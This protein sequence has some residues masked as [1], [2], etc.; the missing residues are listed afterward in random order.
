MI[1]NFMPKKQPT[2][3]EPNAPKPAT[4]NDSVPPDTGSLVQQGSALRSKK[5]K[6]QKEKRDAWKQLPPKQREEETQKS[7]EA[8]STKPKPG[9]EVSHSTKKLEKAKV[10][11]S[12]KE[13]SPDTLKHMTEFMIK[14]FET[15]KKQIECG[16]FSHFNPPLGYHQCF[17]TA[18]DL[19]E[20]PDHLET[21]LKT[22]DIGSV[23]Q[24]AQTIFSRV[25]GLS[26]I[27]SLNDDHEISHLL[28]SPEGFIL[29]VMALAWLDTHSTEKTLGGLV[30]HSRSEKVSG[31]SLP[32]FC[33][34]LKHFMSVV[35]STK[36]PDNCPTKTVT[37]DVDGQRMPLLATAC[38]PTIEHIVTKASP[39]VLE[40]SVFEQLGDS[41][42]FS[43]FFAHII[44]VK[45]LEKSR[46]LSPSDISVKPMVCIQTVV[47]LKEGLNPNVHNSQEMHKL[48]LESAHTEHPPF[49]GQ[50]DPGFPDFRF[51]KSIIDGEGATAKYKTGLHENH[52]EVGSTASVAE[53]ARALK[54]FRGLTVDSGKLAAFLKEKVPFGGTLESFPRLDSRIHLDQQVPI[55]TVTELA[56]TTSHTPVLVAMSDVPLT[57]LIET[58]QALTPGEP[59]PT[60][61]LHVQL[62]QHLGHYVALHAA[63]IGGSIQVFV[64][65]S[66]D[67]PLSA[68]IISS[69]LP[70]ISIT[71]VPLADQIHDQLGANTCGPIALAVAQHLVQGGSVS[72]LVAGNVPQAVIENAQA[73]VA[74]ISAGVVV[75][76]VP[77]TSLGVEQLPS[78]LE[79]I[80]THVLTPCTTEGEKDPSATSLTNEGG[81]IQQ[82]AFLATG[83]FLA[84]ML[85]PLEGKLSNI[86]L[87]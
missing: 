33:A 69:L 38:G 9:A 36:M 28:N 31:R 81:M 43:G 84:G 86:D 55:E 6:E 13:V 60:A 54:P 85:F 19:C 50:S 15:I 22:K 53:K 70:G 46:L 14:N 11:L 35:Q 34:A 64:F 30:V 4:P 80:P 29:R 27:S 47:V 42:R 73:F 44:D 48:M 65:D 24:L 12:E 2:A 63:N 25:F 76:P 57:S 40:V 75:S 62:T 23:I 72:D 68:G 37:C 18:R 66:I 59:L 71:Y 16:D 45:H 7:K 83:L 32:H 82:M 10:P 8:A 52:A 3:N 5:Q 56:A 49:A 17:N 41:V 74:Q 20:H 77:P 26:E 61:I 67:E 87:D 1:V 58:T 78:E 39:Y 79:L 21:L 51:I